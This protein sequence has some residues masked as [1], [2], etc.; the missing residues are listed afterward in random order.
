MENNFMKSRYFSQRYMII[1]GSSIVVAL[2][3]DKCNW[4]FGDQ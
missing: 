2:I 1:I 4:K 3:N